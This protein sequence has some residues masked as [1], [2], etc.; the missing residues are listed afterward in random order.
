MPASW[1]SRRA[2]LTVIRDAPKVLTSSDSLGSRWPT[3]YSPEAIEALILWPTCSYLATLVLSDT[4]IEPDITGNRATRQ[5]RTR[6][7][8]NL[9]PLSGP[10]I[11]GSPTPE[12]PQICGYQSREAYH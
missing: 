5:T 11:S 12:S 6:G 4:A 2:R 9:K 3:L 1:S 8:F 7:G 10:F